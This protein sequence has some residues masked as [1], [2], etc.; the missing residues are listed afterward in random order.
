MV[1]M[2]FII[3]WKGRTGLVYKDASGEY[4]VDGEMMSGE[5]YDHLVATYSISQIDPSGSRIAV[6]EAKRQ[7]ILAGIR[8]Y[9]EVHKMR[10][11]YE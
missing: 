8:S 9:A 2:D 4:Y 3:S 10:I 7:E 5:R 11:F 1:D 6:S